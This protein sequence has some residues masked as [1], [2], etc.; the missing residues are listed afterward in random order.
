MARVQR[1]FSFTDR[2]AIAESSVSARTFVT[3]TGEV[4]LQ[5]DRIAFPAGAERHRNKQVWPTARVICK[6]RDR[7]L[8]VYYNEDIGSVA[9]VQARGANVHTA[10]LPGFKN[11]SGIKLSIRVIDPDTKRLITSIDDF[12]ADNDND[13]DRDELF[14]VLTENLEEEV[15]KVDWE[16]DSP[17]LVVDTQ[18]ADQMLRSPMFAAMV[19]PN[20]LREVLAKAAA[21]FSEDD[22][23]GWESK[24]VRFA[25]TLSGPKPDEGE[26][27]SPAIQGWIERSVAAFAKKNSLKTKM[28]DQ[29]SIERND[30]AA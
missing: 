3:G 2:V 9:E 26:S 21:S 16:S 27:D 7:R 10:I 11:L 29:F 28:M 4:G 14:E 5:I 19:L 13:L 15:W 25:E 18:F 6:A 23:R 22:G 12:R 20:A 30:H 1:R 17:I 24:F 8:D